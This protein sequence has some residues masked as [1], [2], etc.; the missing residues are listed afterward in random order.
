MSPTILFI[1]HATAMGGAE[2]SLL[3]LLDGLDRGRWSLHL[4][5][6]PGEL[7]RQAR[8]RD[9]P[10]HF[11]EMPSLRRLP[12]LT[13]LRTVHALARGIRADIVYANTARAALYAAPAGLLSRRPFIWHVR[14]FSFVEEG[15]R[16]ARTDRHLRWLVSRCASAVV[17]NSAAVARQLPGPDRVRVIHNGID[18]NKLNREWPPPA[19]RR[20]LQLPGETRIVG[21]VGRLRPWKGQERFLRVAA[22]VL[23]QVPG[24]HFVVA[25]GDPFEVGDEYAAKLR[26]LAQDLGIA[27][28]LTFTGHLDE[29]AEVLAAMDLFVHPGDPEPF[30]LVNL[31][32]MAMGKPVVAFAHGA[33]PEI[34]EQDVTGV[35]VPPGDEEACAAAIVELLRTPA[36]MDSL[37]AA[38]RLRVETLFRIERT[39]SAVD[40]LLEQVS[41]RNSPAGQAR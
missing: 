31:E 16:T 26:S 12:R 30:G 11:V 39:V 9:I 14:D 18:L 4:A 22:K 24:T 21:M 34:V 41:V 19:A 23:R 27:A 36:K 35:L 7:A 28:R 5:C 25:G 1:D 29:V 40:R 10:L 17:A 32:A 3:M 13:W 6:C 20:R 15:D 2:N 33:L 37:G 38:G 8:A